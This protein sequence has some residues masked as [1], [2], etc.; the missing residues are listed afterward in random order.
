ME[1]TALIERM[2]EIH[3]LRTKEARKLR[4]EFINVAQEAAKMLELSRWKKYTLAVFE[5]DC[6]REEWR[7]VLKWERGEGLK[8]VTQGTTINECGELVWEDDEEHSLDEITPTM[9]FDQFD[10]LLVALEKILKSEERY[11]EKMREQIEAAQRAL[12]KGSEQ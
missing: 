8:Y 9:A 4:D 10:R 2:K 11:L 6:A 7:K 12:E 5:I 1:T 3:D